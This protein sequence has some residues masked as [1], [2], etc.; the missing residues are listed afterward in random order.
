MLVANSSNGRTNADSG[1]SR[2]NSAK[3]SL[4]QKQDPVNTVTK[5]FSSMLDVDPANDSAYD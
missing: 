2:M 3:N 4:G 1:S 5:R